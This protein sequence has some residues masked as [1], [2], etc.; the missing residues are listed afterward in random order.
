MSAEFARNVTWFTLTG[1]ALREDETRSFAG[2]EETMNER[3]MA[4]ASAF[5]LLAALALA[6]PAAAA[7]RE[8]VIHD[9]AGSPRDGNQPLTDLLLDRAGRLYGTTSAGGS[10]ECKSGA[11]L[12]GCGTAFRLT[13]PAPGKILWTE[14]VYSFPDLAGANPSGLTYA[15]AI[16][17]EPYDGIAPLFGTAAT[18]GAHGGGYVF[19]LVPPGKKDTGWREKTL[20]S[21]ASTGNDGA[22]PL[23]G[24]L[25]DKTGAIYGTTSQ[26]T[27][28]IFPMCYVTSSGRGYTDCGVVFKLT[29]PARGKT[30]WT[31]EVIYRFSGAARADG[32]KPA[33][34]LLMDKTGRLYGTTSIGGKGGCGVRLSESPP[35]SSSLVAARSS[36]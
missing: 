24:L 11:E 20:Y 15:G 23:A 13:P 18:G 30:Q 10:G 9:F 28:A 1:A 2:K 16:R 4:S 25:L 12:I 31:E 22:F 35:S 6:P 36:A 8:T 19:E 33:A 34:E 27:P 26:N 14:S 21:F 3:L 5:A 32:G 29:P 17:G 7:P